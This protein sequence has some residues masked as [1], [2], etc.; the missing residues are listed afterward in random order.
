MTEK[1]T[2]KNPT[3]QAIKSPAYISNSV[4]NARKKSIQQYQNNEKFIT[5]SRSY[6][7]GMEWEELL[8]S[9]E[10]ICQ[11]LFLSMKDFPVTPKQA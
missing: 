11:K 10:S 3:Q 8:P 5:E 6:D 2:E 7:R 1:K 4:Q 9:Y